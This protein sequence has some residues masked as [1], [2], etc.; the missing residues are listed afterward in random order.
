VSEQPEMSKREEGG[1]MRRRTFGASI[2]GGAATLPSLLE[3][4]GEFNM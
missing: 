1:R 3:L 2:V 4:Q